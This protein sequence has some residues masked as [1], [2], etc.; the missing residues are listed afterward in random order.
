MMKRPAILLSI[1]LLAIAAP[2][3]AQSR[4]VD[5]IG[6][7]N[8]VDPNGD[9]TFDDGIDDVNV[10]FDSEQ[11]FG[12]AVN[13]F[14]SNRISTEFAVS[15]VEPDVA[16]ES[17][18][19]LIPAFT[20]GSLEMIPITATLQ[21]HFAPN[22]RI[23]PYIGAGAAYVLFDQLDGNDDLD[24]LDVDQ[25][26]FD[27]DVGFVV[28]AGVSFDITPNFAIYLDGKYVPVSSAATATFATG[29]GTQA[30]VDINPL[31]ISAGLGFQF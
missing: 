1:L 31:I 3:F 8:R 20:G 10:N 4:S 28:N 15:V 18:N 14:W 13:V 26:D 11:G 12:L 27:D 22:A 19:P 2:M 30:D 6:F 25:I 23:D 9:G 7:V 5:V 21:Y 16:F 24:D 17:T 29:P